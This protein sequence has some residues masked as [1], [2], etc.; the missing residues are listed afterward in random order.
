MSDTGY[1][2]EMRP[3]M[4]D[5]PPEGWAFCE[6]QLLPIQEYEG[7]FVIF[8]NDNGRAD[9]TLPNMPRTNGGF[10]WIIR[11]HGELPAAP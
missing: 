7:L 6:G 4:D 1:V 5:T 11:L 3:Y 2:G 10:R 9:F 8:R